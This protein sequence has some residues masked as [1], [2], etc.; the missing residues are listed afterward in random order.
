MKVLVFVDGSEY[1]H[2]AFQTCIDKVLQDDDELFI[3]VFSEL[4]NAT[5]SFEE[6]MNTKV[7]SRAEEIVRDYQMLC[8]P[9]APN[10][11]PIL[12]RL[13]GNPH[14]YSE[15]VMENENICDFIANEIQNKGIDTIVVG[16]KSG[17]YEMPIG[18]GFNR[19]YYHITRCYEHLK[20]VSNCKVLIA[21]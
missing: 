15:E 1:N 21:D 3:I 10:A 4:Q 13:K 14:V 17:P 18:G 20:S 16:G 7:R 2:K 19:A 12:S 6:V 9:K 11:P 5:H 8:D